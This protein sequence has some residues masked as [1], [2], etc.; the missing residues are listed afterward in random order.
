[1]TISWLKEKRHIHGKSFPVWFK[2]ELGFYP[3]KYLIHHRIEA[4]KLLLIETEASG[5]EIALAV[6][7]TSLSSFC[8]TFKNRKGIS[9]TQWWERNIK[10][11]TKLRINLRRFLRQ[12]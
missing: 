1:V 6:G 5:T 8:N 3:R 7:F 12:E 2:H 11:E 10:T 9:P 4:G